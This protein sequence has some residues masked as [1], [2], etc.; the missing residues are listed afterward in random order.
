[1]RILPITPP[2]IDCYDPNNNYM[3]HLNEYEFTELRCKIKERSLDGYYCYFKP[4]RLIEG[5]KIF[6]KS[7]GDLEYWPEGLFDQLSKSLEKLK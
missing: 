4:N 5:K 1:M 7:D 6:I 2:E 3:G